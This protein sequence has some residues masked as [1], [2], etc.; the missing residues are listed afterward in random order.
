MTR[1]VC[2]VEVHDGQHH[3]QIGLQ[4]NYQQVEHGPPEVERELPVTEQCDDQE[5]NLT[6]KQVAEESQGQLH[7]LGQQGGD[8]HDHVQRQGPLAEGVQGQLTYEAAEAL[9]LDAVIKDED[10]NAE[11][12]AERDVHVSGGYGL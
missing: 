7:R 4:R 10:E 5:D 1:L 11:G 3:E 8:F 2:L 9:H 12:Q 6:G